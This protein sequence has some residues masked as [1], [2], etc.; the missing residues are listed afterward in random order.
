LKIAELLNAKNLPGVRFVNKPFIPVSG[1]YAGQHCGGVSVKVTDRAAV[2]SM[3][4]GLEIAA[5][6]HQKYPDHFDVSKI[7]LLLGN[8]STVRQLEAA[9]PVEDIIAS[10]AKDLAAYDAV[11]RRYF[12]YK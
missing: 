2:R 12:L 5:E 9:T 10:W 3:R 4:V 8:D 11:R 7:L 6:L 1:L